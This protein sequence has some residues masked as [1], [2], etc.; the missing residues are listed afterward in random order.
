MVICLE[1]GADLHTA[2]RCHCHSLSL[3]AVKSRLVLPF[4]YRLT[5]VVPEK[6]PLNVCVCVRACVRACVRSFVRSFVR[7]RW[8]HEM[9]ILSVKL[10]SV[11]TVGA[12]MPM[13]NYPTPGGAGAYRPPGS[14][15]PPYTAGGPPS[16]PSQ[17]HPSQPPYPSYPHGVSPYPRPAGKTN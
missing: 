11:Y 1:R 3:A 8:Y 5:R 16:Q 6:G 13:P 2:Q 7:C 12:Q 10:L 14:Y 17:I 4:W 15:P 9:L